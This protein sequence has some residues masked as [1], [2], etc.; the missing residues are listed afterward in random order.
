MS[1]T[2]RLSCHQQS[3]GNTCGALED[4][5]E[6]FIEVM[7]VHHVECDSRVQKGVFR[8]IIVLCLAATFG[9]QLTFP[10]I[11]P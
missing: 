11:L 7:H 9:P 8:R 5:L 2:N 6:H 3:A 1:R 4:K 10:T